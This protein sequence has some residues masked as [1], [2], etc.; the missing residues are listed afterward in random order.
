M[1]KTSEEQTKDMT[2]YPAPKDAAVAT[3]VSETLHKGQYASAT[4]ALRS[5]GRR[6]WTPRQ[7]KQA[8]AAIAHYFS[9]PQAALTPP[10]AEQPEVAVIRRRKIESD[11][12]DKTI[13]FARESATTPAATPRPLTSPS[14][15]LVPAPEGLANIY[16]QLRGE[17]DRRCNE[18]EDAVRK[19]LS[20]AETRIQTIVQTTFDE[21]V[22][23]FEKGRQVEAME[24]HGSLSARRGLQAAAEAH[25]SRGRAHSGASFRDLID[26]SN[27]AQQVLSSGPVLGKDAAQ[28]WR[29][30]LTTIGTQLGAQLG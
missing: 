3:W 13:S 7:K 15:R 27:T 24:A 29:K 12:R 8:A 23:E 28:A 30:V 11:P 9:E 17:V 1:S 2:A 21:R 22:A 19:L 5:L 25:M 10:P 6:L 14:G 26:V 16:D 18:S 20:E 4:N